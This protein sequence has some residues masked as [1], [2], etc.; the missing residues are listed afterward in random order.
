MRR[1]ALWIETVLAA[2]VVIGVCVQVYLIGA[3]T[4]RAG[5]DALDAHRNVGGIVH[6]VEVLVLVAALV[7]FWGVRWGWIGHAA[8]LPIIGTIQLAFANGDRWVGAFHG[9]LALAV[10]V[11]AASIVRVNLVELRPGGRR[12]V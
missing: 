5:K 4:F 8:S 11:I 7:A 6:I 3:Y 2:L 1:S 10:L 12:A 9:L